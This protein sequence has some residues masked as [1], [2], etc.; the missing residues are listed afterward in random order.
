MKNCSKDPT[1]PS[2]NHPFLRL[3]VLFSILLAVFSLS[4]CGGGSGGGGS[5]GGSSGT[6]I[7]GSV[8]LAS[9]N[10]SSA[11][12][13][14]S[15]P[16][17]GNGTIP[18]GTPKATYNS[19]SSTPCNSGSILSGGYDKSYGLLFVYTNPTPTSVTV[20]VFSVSTGGVL[21]YTGNTALNL[22][23][24]GSMSVDPTDH[25]IDVSQSTGPPNLYSYTSS[26][27]ISGRVIVKSS[28]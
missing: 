7:V 28:V 8:I 14:S 9:Q 10:S 15:F 1:L 22:T 3:S 24:D 5:T 4:A 20:C 11:Y 23:G 6:S 18:S 13:L 2:K 12:Q 17:Q 19:F 21:S 27:V 26:G 16:Y 25:Y